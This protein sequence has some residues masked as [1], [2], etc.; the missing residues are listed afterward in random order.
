M[1]AGCFYFSMTRLLRVAPHFR[2][3]SNEK[4]STMRSSALPFFQRTL[5]RHLKPGIPLLLLALASL[6]V[7]GQDVPAYEE[8]ACYVRRNLE[9]NIV[10]FPSVFK[11]A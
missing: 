4:P 9:L 3:T 11:G 7:Y 2:T 1:I 8:Q 5:K 6:P 10:P